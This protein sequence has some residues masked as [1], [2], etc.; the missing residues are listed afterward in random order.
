MLKLYVYRLSGGYNMIKLILLVLGIILTITTIILLITKKSVEAS[1]VSAI[2]AMVAYSISLNPSIFNQE[3]IEPIILLNTDLLEL[4]TFDEY[5]LKATVFPDNCD[6]IWESNNKKIVTVD[7]N[8]HLEAIANGEATIY[9]TITYK[10]IEYFDTCTISVK[11]PS[12]NLNIPVSLNAPTLLYIN[13][14]EKKK[15][16]ATTIPENLKI[17]W[18]SNN[19]NVVN[20]ND[21]GE[22]EGLSKGTTLITATIVYKHMA[23]ATGCTVKVNSPIDNNNNDLNEH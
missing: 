8:G 22:I 11:D 14:G 1:I 16:N 2:F 19:T 5:D 13:I 4:I 7:N 20:I 10:D 17:H 18:E 3:K 6:I 9:A 15:I 23:I 12:I 21:Q